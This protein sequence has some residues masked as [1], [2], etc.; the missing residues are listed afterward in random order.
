MS[1]NSRPVCFRSAAALATVA[2]VAALGMGPAPAA[3]ATELPPV[4]AEPA[5]SIPAQGQPEDSPLRRAFDSTL[6]EARE[7]AADEEDTEAQAATEGEAPSGAGQVG[8][9]AAPETVIDDAPE[10]SA[11]VLPDAVQEMSGGAAA[12]QPVRPQATRPQAAGYTVSGSVWG[13]YYG[14]GDYSASLDE[15]AAG[16]EVQLLAKDG[17]RVRTSITDAAGRYAF[18]NLDAGTYR[19]RFPSVDDVGFSFDIDDDGYTPS[20]ELGPEQTSFTFDLP[21]FVPEDWPSLAF[22][23]YFDADRDG[24]FDED[25]AGAPEVDVEI[26][27]EDGSLAATAT[28]DENGMSGGWLDEGRYRLRLS[29]PDGYVVSGAEAYLYPF[30]D[31]GPQALGIGPDGLTDPFDVDG[32]YSAMIAIGLAEADAVAPAAPDTEPAA[33]APAPV[34][35]P[36]AAGSAEA[37]PAE[38]TVP[39]LAETGSTTTPL[40]PLAALALATGVVL[41][42][43]VRRK[44]AA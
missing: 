8:G 14:D 44:P 42:R 19:L 25:E 3:L 33:M 4:G 27:S 31:E 24:I 28:T 17:T 32:E 34:A 7:Q 36:A 18:E 40:V 37:Q 5:G 30:E 10:G 6:D 12:Q 21:L 16:I 23:A 29:V 39:R 26:L 20:F 43:L 1:S 41:L 9:A 2:A 38:A 22:A 15:W 35:Q 11:M 13:D